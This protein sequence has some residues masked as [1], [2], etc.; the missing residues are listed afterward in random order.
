MVGNDLGILREREPFEGR[1]TLRC[2]DV[3]ILIDKISAVVVGS[4]PGTT[5]RT[6]LFVNHDFS[7]GFQ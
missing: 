7:A 1:K 2:I 5:D 6:A 3:E 4:Q